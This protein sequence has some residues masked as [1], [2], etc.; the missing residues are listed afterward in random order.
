[1]LIRGLASLLPSGPTPHLHAASV[2]SRPSRTVP[3]TPPVDNYVQPAPIHRATTHVSS[4][5]MDAIA[6]LSPSGA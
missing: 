3:G 1:M 6:S 4:R 5:T 2:H